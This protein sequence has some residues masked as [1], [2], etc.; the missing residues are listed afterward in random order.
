MKYYQ[1]LHHTN[2]VNTLSVALWLELIH[3]RVGILIESRKY[4]ELFLLFFSSIHTQCLLR[5]FGI[6]VQFLATVQRSL[7]G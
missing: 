6:L 2:G 3:F 4:L 7:G 1:P 5:S